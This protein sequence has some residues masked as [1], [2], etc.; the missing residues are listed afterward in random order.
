MDVL[1][2]TRL[3]LV[4]HKIET[5]T[6][7]EHRSDIDAFVWIP[8]DL[9]DETLIDNG[10][11]K[12]AASEWTDDR[13]AMLRSFHREFLSA[14][15]IARR[16][17][18]ETGSTFTRNAIIGKLHRLG[19][20]AADGGSRSI[21]NRTPRKTR[22]KTPTDEKAAALL[23]EINAARRKGKK[24]LGEDD[25]AKVVELAQLQ[26]KKTTDEYFAPLFETTPIGILELSS[27]TCHWP[28]GDRLYC[29][30]EATGRY[31]KQHT[32]MGRG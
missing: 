26:L 19:L 15:D 28:V 32:D 8:Y 27:T 10:G 20:T 2:T 7:R 6:E 25:E 14:T 3:S 31:C 24:H 9:D 23:R 22:T 18:L 11:T 1:T 13:V 30:G 16:L 5:R 17:N 21:Q 12:M 4:P 29:G